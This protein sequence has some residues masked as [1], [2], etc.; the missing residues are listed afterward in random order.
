MF[1][2]LVIIKQNIQILKLNSKKNSKLFIDNVYLLYFSSYNYNI[3]RKTEVL[4]IL[5][6]NKINCLFFNVKNLDISFD[7]IN[8]IDTIQLTDSFILFP[9]KQNYK[10]QWK[11]EEE[12]I[13]NIS[14]L[15]N[16]KRFIDNKIKNY[17]ECNIKK[18]SIED[19]YYKQFL[20]Y[21][22][23]KTINDT[24][25]QH[26]GKFIHIYINSF[27]ESES[28]PQI[29]LYLF[30]FEQINGNI[31]FNAKLGLIYIDD[32]ENLYFLILKKIN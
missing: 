1:L 4:N 21:F 8:N 7:F 17:Q 11:E 27:G 9:D 14:K 20:D 15:L 16:K 25:L 6:N 18:F 3:K 31:D 24:I 12:S 19:N 5:N 10:S 2:Y 26:L 23:N 29:D 28:V 30:V 13:N 22:K 32:Y